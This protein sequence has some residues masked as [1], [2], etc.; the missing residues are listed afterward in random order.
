M[1]EVK[2][3]MLAAAGVVIAVGAV[4]AGVLVRD[5][6]DLGLKR[7]N[8]GSLASNSNLLAFKGSEVPEGDYFY[9]LSKLL[10]REYVEPMKDDQKL[11]SGAVRGMVASLG[12]PKSL[13]MDRDEF[14][15]YQNALRGEYEG[16]GAEMILSVP[17]TDGKAVTGHP[18]AGEDAA[19]PVTSGTS[20]IPKLVVATVVPGGPADKVGV[21]PGDWVHSVDGRW[22]IDPD[23][24]N[25]FRKLQLLV[26]DPRK[27]NQQYMEQYRQMRSDLRPK[28]EHSL[29]PNRAKDRLMIGTSGTVQIVWHRGNDLRAT[30]VPKGKSALPNFTEKDGVITLPF[31]AGSAAALK[32]AIDGRGEVTIDLRNN[33]LGDF[34]EMRACLATLAPSGNYGVLAGARADRSRNL[35][36]EN[37]NP[38]PPKVTLLADQTTRGPAQLFALALSA[39]GIAKIEG[40]GMEPKAYYVETGSLPDGTGFTLATAEFRPAG[41]TKGA[42]K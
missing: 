8:P 38:K 33:V 27:P 41:T 15:A 9:E 18:G 10:K 13:Y 26:G 3:S 6:V 21:K 29:L 39:K 22:V 35:A 24:V 31:E 42:S 5:R 12:D 2:T 37:G 28:L 36:I 17:A 16:I 4:V 32:R 19:D 34:E 20:R 30:N 23:T 25:R 14:T 40:S 1:S 7:T 11:A